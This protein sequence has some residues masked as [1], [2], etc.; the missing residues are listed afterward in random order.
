MTPGELQV[1]MEY[2]QAAID[3]TF[4]H[5]QTLLGGDQ[6]LV[7][8]D[9]TTDPN[10]ADLRVNTQQHAYDL[11]NSLREHMGLPPSAPNSPLSPDDLRSISNDIAR[12]NTPARFPNPSDTRVH[13]PNRLEPVEQ[14]TYQHDVED[15]LRNG[16]SFV[17]GADPRTNQYGRLVN[18][19]GPHV[20]GRS[21]NCLD[22]SLSAL[23]SFY[24]VPQ[25]SA[26]RWP[27]SLPD[28]T[29][30]DRN[31]EVG[32]TARAAAWLGET[33]LHF[34]GVPIPAQFQA[35]HDHVAAM[36]PGSSAL[37][38]N[39]WQAYKNGIPQ[40]NPDGSPEIDGAH[41]TVIVYPPGA[42][43]PV[44]WDPQSGQTFDTPP[45]AMVA[46]SVALHFYPVDA[47]GGMHHAGTSS[48]SGT[49]PTTAGQ[50]LRPESGVLGSG[51]QTRLGGPWDLD[52]G[53]DVAG[54]GTRAGELRPEQTHRGD[55]GA[56]EPAAGPDRGG[57]R[58][59]D[60]NGPTGAG[61]P[62]ISP[63]PS[64]SSI[65]DLR[66]PTNGPVSG[67]SDGAGEPGQPADDG[68]DHDRQGNPALPAERWTTVAGHGVGRDA[69]QN[70]GILADGGNDRPVTSTVDQQGASDAAAT[71]SHNGTT[72]G[73]P[74]SDLS[75]PGIHGSREPSRVDLSPDSDS[76]GDRG[77]NGSR[78]G[79]LRSGQDDRGSHRAVELGAGNDR[80]DVRHG[81]RGR[82]AAPSRAG[83]P[84]AEPVDAQ[85]DPG[86]P[87]RDRVPGDG[88][89]DGN[90]TSDD[91]GP[92][93]DDQQDNLGNHAVHTTGTDGGRP[94]GVEPGTPRRV[95]DNGDV[96]GLAGSRDATT[97]PPGAVESPTPR[98]SSPA[99]DVHGATSPSATTPPGQPSP[100]PQQSLGTSPTPSHP[101]N[102]QPAFGQT[103]LP[104]ISPTTATSTNQSARA[105]RESLRGLPSQDG[106]TVPVDAN[107]SPFIQRPPA[108][109]IRRFHLGGNQ[110]VAV[111]TI[112]AHIPNAHLMSPADLRQAME[113]IQAR[114]DVTFNNGS[115][116]LSGDLLLVDLEFTTDPQDADL[117]LDSAQHPNRQANILREHIG[118]FPSPPGTMLSPDDLREISND[119]A[120]ANTPTPFSDPADSRVVDHNHLDDIEDSAYQSEV[121]DLLRDGNSFVT[122]ADPRTHPYG[123]AINDGGR[124][125]PGRGNNCLDCSLSALSSFFGLPRVS[126]PRWPDV[127]D[128]GTPDSRSG[129]EDGNERAAT[130]LGRDWVSYSGISGMPVVAQYQ[131]LH[132]YIATLGPGS[133]ALVATGWH[134]RDQNGARR[135]N[136]D[137]TPVIEEGHATVIVFPPGAAG[138]V[139]WDPQSGETSD[140]PPPA[141]LED[142]GAMWCIPIDANNGGSNNGAT[143]AG[144]GTGP[145]VA[146]PSLRPGEDV[147]HLGEQ[148]RLGMPRDELPGQHF[149][150]AD[151]DP[152]PR[153]FRDQQAHRGDHGALEH[154]HDIDRRGIRPDNGSGPTAPGLSGISETAPNPPDTNLG[155]T[156][157]HRVPGR[158]DVPGST[159]RPGDHP[160]S[161]DHQESDPPPTHG[162][163]LSTGDI[164]GIH[165]EPYH[166]N[167]ARGGDDRGVAGQQFTAASATPTPQQIQNANRAR[168]ARA[169]LRT[170]RPDGGVQPVVES[171]RRFTW[172]RHVSA[173]D[174][175]V[176][177]LR[178]GLRM[179][180]RGVDPAV[181]AALHAR[182][183]LAVDL[184][185]NGGGQFANGDWVM[186]DLVPVANSSAADMELRVDNSGLPG[187]ITP[188]ADMSEVTAHLRAQLGLE[189]G[190]EQLS[191]HD[192]QQ[193]SSAIDRATCAPPTPPWLTDPP[194]GHASATVSQPNSPF[195]PALVNVSTPMSR[196]NS[197][198]RKAA[199]TP[200]AA[201]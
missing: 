179:D 73:V 200:A 181:L 158:P 37:L 31:G 21:N 116:L 40:F 14:A 197:W 118:L 190:G 11:A 57:V 114:V 186:A 134:A 71:T 151:A 135:Y 58:P 97:Q 176:S 4:N 191:P 164:V 79:E 201:A 159:G 173:F 12:A 107:R 42:S 121:E 94:S 146:G 95:A 43:G 113:S 29:R 192:L 129:E 152:R 102:D 63:A 89:V 182:L 131:A 61:Q 67:P 23:S 70:N 162:S 93:S 44:W 34:G 154:G 17:V 136:P 132:N 52:G 49:G 65:E 33:P 103:P 85:P 56:S 86:G 193:L 139:W 175:P 45:P 133:A 174:T 84:A 106:H 38:I 122:G 140:V 148:P 119:I 35:L 75:D 153:E 81:D 80:A 99:G 169:S 127:N 178:I 32:G 171:G 16:N 19:G 5:A 188:E 130:W 198:P 54:D 155:G 98:E 82:E 168:A 48:H 100:V 101:P 112:R 41:A 64:N 177:V 194:V 149:T 199:P 125:E 18:D 36:G 105:L 161:R 120:R 189:P 39:T 138:P 144:Q 180:A 51:V 115:R 110:W 13:G 74:G 20:P 7:D 78:P 25:V 91:R 167:L 53:R 22:C 3:A 104:A 55:H 183:Q 30:D 1:E 147:Q 60:R 170:R 109:R 27:D 69:Q 87:R 108:Y 150:P 172:A 88:R 62:G 83:L 184:H 50:G 15:Q 77:G 66:G 90:I 137:G 165:E 46:R 145:T 124:E 96:R 72:A 6:F 126:A 143:S 160:G 187:T 68:P 142:A 24:G 26:P 92:A 9:F 8:I 141:L 111:A 47:N 123:Q 28:G 196:L 166:G 59:G 10:T 157:H 2:A 163:G 128:D 156:E 195:P 117:E 76:E 185:F